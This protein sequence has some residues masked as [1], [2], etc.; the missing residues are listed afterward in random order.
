MICIWLPGMILGW[1]TT[2]LI[3]KQT[4]VWLTVKQVVYRVTILSMLNDRV[5]VTF[6]WL[7]KRLRGK[8][9]NSNLACRFWMFVK[10]WLK[11]SILELSQMG[12]KKVSFL[13]CWCQRAMWNF[14]EI[15]GEPPNT[16][17]RTCVVRWCGMLSKV[18][19]LDKSKLMK[20]MWLPSNTIKC[21]KLQ[22]F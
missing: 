13:H 12:E 19:K 10:K 16:A 3:E 9:P 5:F 18:S 17:R 22:F 1:K 14:C 4:T 8:G 6:L 21:E 20:S 2:R 11:V 7:K 15:T